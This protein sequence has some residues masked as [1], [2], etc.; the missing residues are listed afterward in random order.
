MRVKSNDWL[1][2]IAFKIQLFLTM[3]DSRHRFYI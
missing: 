2:V 1:R 3:A